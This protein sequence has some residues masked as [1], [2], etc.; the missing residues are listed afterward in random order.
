MQNEI[1]IEQ[2]KI[3]CLNED[4]KNW[5]KIKEQKIEILNKI[6]NSLNVIRNSLNKI[7]N[8]ITGIKEKWQFMTTK[9]KQSIIRALVEKIIIEND[10]IRIISSF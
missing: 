4:K 3:E 10:T 8:E 5:E 6:S 9:E 7:K 2:S 1:E